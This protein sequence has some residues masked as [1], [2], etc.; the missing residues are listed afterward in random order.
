MKNIGKILLKTIPWVIVITLLVLAFCVVYM[1]YLLPPYWD[2]TFGPLDERFYFGPNAFYLDCMLKQGKFPLWNPLSYCGMPFAA[3][4]QSSACYP[5]HLI[6]A[7]LTPAFDPYATVVSLH[8]TR[9][10]HILLAGVG[11]IL[12]LKRYSIGWMSSLVG[13]LIFMFNAYAIIY[14]T[15]FYVYPL[16]ISWTPWI[17]W[18][19]HGTWYAP[20]RRTS[21][22]YMYLVI[23]FFSL[24]TLAGFPQL[25]L[26]V[27]LI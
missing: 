24:S 21:L 1:Y 4:P 11:V 5:P 7:W 20:D 10:L 25:S 22:V 23:L 13:A 2:K 27:G 16:V 8:V 26:Y 15:E 14:Y 18:A 19:A 6:R 9:F 17:L 3:D 12:L